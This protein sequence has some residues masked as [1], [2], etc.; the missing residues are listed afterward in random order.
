MDRGACF[1]ALG[2]AAD[3]SY[4]EAHDAFRHLACATHPDLGGDAT[5]FAAVHAA[6][7]TLSPTLV[8]RP[9]PAAP[10]PDPV[11]PA[12]AAPAPVASAASAPATSSAAD[13]FVRR[14]RA[15]YT[16]SATLPP[17]RPLA[18]RAA[19]RRTAPRPAAP[20][21]PAFSRLLDAALAAA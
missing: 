6:W 1:A 10:A 15:S 19:V 21:D 12:P 11:V 18:R 8:R 3:A 5:R 14:A 7:R 20:V 17:T 2:I 16:A 9:R 4:D 13:P